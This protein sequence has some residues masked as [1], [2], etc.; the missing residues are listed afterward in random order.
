MGGEIAAETKILDEV[1]LAALRTFLE[2][3]VQK[4]AASGIL[5]AATLMQASRAEEMM[6]E[7]ETLLRFATLIPG[8]VATPAVKPQQKQEMFMLFQASALGG[9]RAPR[10]SG[11][12]R[13]VLVVR[14]LVFETERG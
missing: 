2:A 4:K 7:L 14:V 10:G 3:T 1:Q 12:E 9:R 8:V 13:V 5:Q 11:G 6:E